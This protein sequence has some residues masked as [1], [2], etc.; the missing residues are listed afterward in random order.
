MGNSNY[1]MTRLAAKESRRNQF[2]EFMR[3]EEKERTEKRLELMLADPQILSSPFD[4][5]G[6][7]SDIDYSSIKQMGYTQSLISRIKNKFQS[8]G[9]EVRRGEIRKVRTYRELLMLIGEIQIGALRDLGKKVEEAIISH[10]KIK[11]YIRPDYNSHSTLQI[12]QQ[13]HPDL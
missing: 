9:T 7:D 13:S 3:R 2:S 11:G 5:S 10:L 6:L 1:E 8:K 12:T 4:S